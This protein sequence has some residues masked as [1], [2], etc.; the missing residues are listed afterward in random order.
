MPLAFSVWDGFN[1]ERGNKRAL[2]PWFNL[3]VEP[4]EMVSKVGPMIRAALI[5]LVVELLAV[6]YVRRRFAAHSVPT[7]PAVPERA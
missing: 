6:F 5:A 1:N 7:G 2:S 4:G 3:Y